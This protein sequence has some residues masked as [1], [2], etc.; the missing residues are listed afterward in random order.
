M[1]VT[2]ASVLLY[3]LMAQWIEK[4][5]TLSS[6]SLSCWCLRCWRRLEM[7]CAA[8]QRETKRR[9]KEE[10]FKYCVC[11][12][13]LFICSKLNSYPY[14]S[15]STVL[16]LVFYTMST[17]TWEPGTTRVLLLMNC[18]YVESRGVVHKYFHFM[19]FYISRF[20]F[21]IWHTC[22]ETLPYLST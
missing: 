8:L 15:V 11:H 4:S 20:H 18:S 17:D 19:I 14:F 10:T 2:L 6:A 1:S 7:C 22:T 13:Y 16:L 12:G 9:E 21:V 5:I 3:C